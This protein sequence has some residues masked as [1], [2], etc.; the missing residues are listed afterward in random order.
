MRRIAPRK[1]ASISLIVVLLFLPA[2]FTLRA[3]PGR[4]A[5]LDWARRQGRGHHDL[6]SACAE[7]GRAPT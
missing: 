1:L 6:T 2:L 3:V 5:Y 7:S 4:L